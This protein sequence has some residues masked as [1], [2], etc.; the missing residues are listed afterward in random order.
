[1]DGHYE[2]SRSSNGQFNFVLKAGNGETILQGEQYTTK[3]SAQGGIA[4]VQA[5]C[6]DA[7]R[8]EKKVARNGQ[9]YFTLKAANHQ[10]VGTSETYTTATSRDRGIESVRSNGVS[11]TIDDLTVA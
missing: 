9:F 1:M 8:Y 6:G 4:A 7:A 5:N 10:V 2:I 11:T 3:A